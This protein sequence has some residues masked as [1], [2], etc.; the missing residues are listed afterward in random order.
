MANNYQEGINTAE[1]LIT[2][3]SKDKLTILIDA[4]ELV[5][6]D[7]DSLEFVAGMKG[8]TSKVTY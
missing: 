6:Y 2:H 4:L 8:L 3:M 5:S 1:K 7:N